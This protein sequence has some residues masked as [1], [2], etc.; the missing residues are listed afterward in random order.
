MVNPD[1]DHWIA[2]LNP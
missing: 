2:V 1:A